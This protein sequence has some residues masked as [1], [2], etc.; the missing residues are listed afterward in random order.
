MNLPTV[1]RDP[2][3]RHRTPFTKEFPTCKVGIDFH[4]FDK[5]KMPCLGEAP[6]VCPQFANWTPEE[7]AA[8]EA[9]IEQH[10]RAI[11][12][13]RPAIVAQVKATGIRA[14]TIPC[15]A[16]KTGTVHYS[17]AS[18]GHV[19]ARCSTAGCASWME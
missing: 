9:R 19:H 4:K 11:G 15:P 17:Q 2:W 6:G 14:A 7:L 12:V 1:K 3:C 13:I 18:N 16:C 5:A 10:M 8:R